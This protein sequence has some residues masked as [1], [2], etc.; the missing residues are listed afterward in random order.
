M[1]RLIDA[2][3]RSV[4]MKNYLRMLSL[5]AATVAAA[6]LALTVATAPASAAEEVAG[7]TDISAKASSIERRHGPSRIGFFRYVRPVSPVPRHF[8]CT[9]SWCGRHFVLM[10]GIGY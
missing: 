6:A 2:S 4:E 8:E 7:A 3:K 10:I 5:S 1:L 9:G